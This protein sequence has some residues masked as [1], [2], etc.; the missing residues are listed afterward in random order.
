MLRRVLKPVIDYAICAYLVLILAVMPFYNQAGYKRIGTDKSFYFN[1][2]TVFMCRTLMPAV[3]VYLIAIL[4]SK[5][6]EFWNRLRRDVTL[7]DLFAAGYALALL[8]SWLLSEYRSDALWGAKGWYMGF[9]P[10]M[11]LVLIYFLVSKLWKPRAWMLYLALGASAAVFLLG[12]LNR[13]GIDPLHMST[14]KSSFISTIGNIN[15]YCGYLV[16]VFFA[17]VVLLWKCNGEKPWQ[18]VLLMLYVAVGFGTLVTQG[19][20]SGMVTLVVIMLV[21]FVMSAPDRDRMI[22]FWEEILLLGEVCLITYAIRKVGLIQENYHGGLGIFLISGWRPL[23]VTAVSLIVLV[24]LYR[25]RDHGSYPEKSIRILSRVIAATAAGAVLLVLILAAVNTARPGSLGALSKYSLFTFSPQW[26]SNRGATW[27]AGWKC[28]V[29]Q[30]WLHRMVGIGPDTMSAYIYRD[31]SESLLSL[32]R[33]RF[34]NKTLSNAHNEWLTVLVNTGIVGLTAFAGMVISAI[35]RFLR[36]GRQNEIVCACGFCMLAYTV[37]N[38]FSFQQAM[39]VATIFVIFGMGSA[40]LR[41][42]TAKEANGT[43]ER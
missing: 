18:K 42:S 16:S 24:L 5:K 26:G 6:R 29:E 34:E 31:G 19:S 30:N 28:F 12:Y 33:E 40:F 3:A 35:R 22:L 13:F 9:G 10:Q 38:I 41:E 4:I 14:D 11:F 27:T 7:T 23:F 15:W 39:S 21:L 17:G 32:V 20:D 1:A 8:V 2:V 36:E 43:A 25:N 37:N